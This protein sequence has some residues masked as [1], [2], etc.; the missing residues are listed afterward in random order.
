[1]AGSPNFDKS[2][3]PE[4]QLIKLRESARSG[5]AGGATRP[6]YNYNAAPLTPSAEAE[7]AVAAASAPKG[8]T[9]EL[10]PDAND[11]DMEE[12]LGILQSRGYEAAMKAVAQMNSPHIEDDFHRLLVRMK[13]DGH[14]L[15]DDLPDDIS[16]ALDMVLYEV[17]IVVGDEDTKTVQDVFTQMQQFY[18][19]FIPYVALPD[20]I[21]FKD[22]RVKKAI[23]ND[24]FVME[25]SVSHGKEH[26][27]FYMSVQRSRREVFEKQMHS[28]FPKAEVQEAKDD[29][30]IF[31]QFGAVAASEGQFVNAAPLAIRHGEGFSTDP[32]NVTLSAFSR[33]TKEGEGAALQ[34]VVM[35]AGAFHKNKISD[36]Y[37]DI[38]KGKAPRDVFLKAKFTRPRPLWRRILPELWTDILKAL[39]P[40]DKKKDGDKSVDS[41]ASE[42]I[43]KKLKQPIVGVNIRLIASARTEARA[44]A[45][46]GDLEATFGQYDDPLGNRLKFKRKDGHDLEHFIHEYIFRLHDRGIEHADRYFPPYH[47]HPFE[48]GM[49]RLNYAELAALFHFTISGSTSSREVNQTGAKQAP[50]PIGLLTEGTVLGKNKYGGVTTDIHFGKLDRMRHMYVIGQTGTGKTNL[51]MTSIV[52]DMENGDGV[53]FI[54]PLGPDVLKILAAVPKHRW[55]DVIYFDP[56]YTE[57]PFG[58]NMLEYDPRHPEQKTFVIDEMFNIFKKLYGDQPEAFGPIFEQYFR[59]GTAL[60]LEDPDTGSTLMDIARV[61]SDEDYRALKLSRCKNPVVAHFWEDVAEKVR[62]EGSLANIV[63]YITSK[64]DIF[65]ANEIMRPIVGQQRSAFNFKDIM[66]NKKILLVNLSKGRLGDVNS[67]LLGLIIVGKIMQTAFARDISKNPPPFF[68]YLDEFHNVVT[69]TIATVLSEG[70]KFGLSLTMAHQFLS[71]LEPRSGVKDA[72][73]G[74]VG[75]MAVFRIGPDDAKFLETQFLP[76]FNASDMLQIDNYKYFLKLLSGGKPQS[77]F[78]VNA[79][80]F[81][82]GTPEDMEVLK[83]MSYQRYGRAREVV[84]AEVREKYERM[85]G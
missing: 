17:S 75:S 7:V 10:T 43:S 80:P 33:I 4:A 81:V 47:P 19:A 63:P 73:F 42:S 46:L 53:C 44:K 6:G 69:K 31:N 84:D 13:H 32:L 34:I 16:K 57:R 82:D 36:A 2:Q 76:T 39:A 70:R 14:A 22:W 27:V 85:N 37:K 77:P 3:S 24:Y 25:L 38:Q 49:L 60:V 20:P 8:V 68:L 30:N 41:F 12:L 59:N 58:L 1:M 55:D 51:L 61:L 72:V 71:Q 56:A 62:G 15:P 50:A 35:S 5:G 26:A 66:D 21:F 64:F 83:Q 79:P 67:N 40:G 29:Y 74:N 54:D 23:H 45:I 78:T 18:L 28:I 48:N 65:L 11:K 52:Q 9:L